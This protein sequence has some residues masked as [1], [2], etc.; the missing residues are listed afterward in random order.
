MNLSVYL[1][2][3]LK[4]STLYLLAYLSQSDNIVSMRSEGWKMN[5][6][7]FGW[8]SCWLTNESKKKKKKKKTRDELKSTLIDLKLLWW[9]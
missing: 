6:S 7:K 1:G 4:T 9:N 3:A 5:W 2:Q 8:W